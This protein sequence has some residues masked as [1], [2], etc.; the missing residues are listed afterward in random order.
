MTS[1]DTYAASLLWY[2][3][4]SGGISSTLEEN[5]SV[6]PCY[7]VSSWS[8]LEELV[9]ADLTLTHQG[10]RSQRHLMAQSLVMSMRRSVQELR[11]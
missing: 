9:W 4:F 7:R 8:R 6:V 2:D 10:R 5:E 1:E 11:P 3:E